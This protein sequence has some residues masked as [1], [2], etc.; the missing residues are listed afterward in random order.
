MPAP[1]TKADAAKW[2][3]FSVPGFEEAD[4]EQLNAVA[5]QAGISRSEMVRDCIRALTSNAQLF[6]ALRELA[7]RRGVPFADLVRTLLLAKV[8]EAARQPM[9]KTP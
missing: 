6:L 8:K 7:S 5:H 4:I 1:K 2:K 9:Q 3:G